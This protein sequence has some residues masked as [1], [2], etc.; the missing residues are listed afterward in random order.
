MIFKYFTF[1][2]GAFRRPYLKES[3]QGKQRC[4][5]VKDTEKHETGTFQTLPQA[6]NAL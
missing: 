3:G 2:R 1:T 4:E 5:N 6:Q